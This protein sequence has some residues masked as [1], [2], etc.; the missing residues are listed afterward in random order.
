MYRKRAIHAHLAILRPLL[1]WSPTKLYERIPTPKNNGWPGLH[2]FCPNVG[3]VSYFVDTAWVFV[4][5]ISYLDTSSIWVVDN[6]FYYDT[7]WVLYTMQG[8]SYL[9]SKKNSVIFIWYILV[10]TQIMIEVGI[11]NSPRLD[12]LT[13]YQCLTGITILIPH[14]RFLDTIIGVE[15]FFIPMHSLIYHSH[16]SVHPNMLQITPK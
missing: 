14:D 1:T 11:Q 7:I 13:E 6:T 9:G 10:L 8:P 5:R 16:I 15:G 3:P 4:M 12:I 2:G